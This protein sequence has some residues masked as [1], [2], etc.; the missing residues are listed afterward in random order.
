MLQHTNET[1]RDVSFSIG[2]LNTK[3]FSRE[4]KKGLEKRPANT[5][6][7][8]INV[9]M[10]YILNTPPY[11][12]FLLFRRSRLFCW[13]SLRV[14]LSKIYYRR[15]GRVAETQVWPCTGFR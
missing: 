5:G 13:S 9:R 1:V 4:I 3:Y 10:N 15:G 12:L 2:Y 7:I 11:N 6:S 14:G 8:I